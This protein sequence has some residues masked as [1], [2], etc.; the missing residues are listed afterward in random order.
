MNTFKHIKEL[1]K[2]GDNKTV[3]NLIEINNI[4]FYPIDEFDNTFIHT[5][6]LLGNIEI[7]TYLLEK[8]NN[9]TTDINKSINDVNALGKTA[10]DYAIDKEVK[11]LLINY[12][13]KTGEEIEKQFEKME[14]SYY[15]AMADIT[16]IQLAKLAGDKMFKAIIDDDVEEFIKLYNSDSEKGGLILYRLSSRNNENKTLLGKA[17]EL[18]RKEIV[19]FINSKN[20]KP[21]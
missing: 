10:L 3:I 13:A 17:I 16:K 2:K 18:N 1:I 15:N 20:K 5:A 9:E 14:E 19:Y 21:I 12:G 7:L 8:D 11:L 4:H 6:S